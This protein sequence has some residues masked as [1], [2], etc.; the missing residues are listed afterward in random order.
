MGGVGGH[1]V[2]RAL[3]AVEAQVVGA[4]GL[5][6]EPLLDGLGKPV[7]PPESFFDLAGQSVG[8]RAQAGRE[9]PVTEGVLGHLGLGTF[10]RNNEPLVL[11]ER[12]GEF[13]DRSI[14]PD[15]AVSGILPPL[16]VITVG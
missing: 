9:A 2:D 13:G 5:P 7:C 15:D 11:T 14:A 6:P 4:L 8:L 1:R 3:V 16:V 12:D 10:R